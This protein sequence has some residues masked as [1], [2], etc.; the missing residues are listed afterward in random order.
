MCHVFELQT[1]IATHGLIVAHRLRTIRNR[2]TKLILNF[3]RHSSAANRACPRTHHATS[4][5][6]KRC[7]CTCPKALFHPHILQQ[8]TATMSLSTPSICSLGSCNTTRKA[9]RR[10]H[11]SQQNKKKPLLRWAN[12][13]DVETV[14]QRKKEMVE[15]TMHR[16]RSW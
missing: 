16:M 7:M 13:E 15:V 8:N 9:A 6:R 2:A 11:P 14:V 10:A 5:S 4:M 1:N 12:C 3:I